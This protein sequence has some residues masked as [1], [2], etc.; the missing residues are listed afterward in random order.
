MQIYGGRIFLADGIARAKSS[1]V[2]SVLDVFSEKQGVWLEG[3][4]GERGKDA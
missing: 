1:Q 3:S 2:R 4:E